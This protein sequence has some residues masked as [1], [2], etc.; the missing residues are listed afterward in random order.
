MLSPSSSP[1]P[2]RGFGSDN[3]SG[4]HPAILA[5]I[6]A[7]NEGHAP[8]YQTDPHSAAA[9]A[10]FAR[11]LGPVTVRYVFNGTGANV[12]ALQAITPAYGAVLCADTA[13]IHVD[14]C[15]APERFIGCKLLA[16]RGIHGKLT[17]ELLAPYLIRGGDQHFAAP[18]AVSIAQ[19]TELGT[20]Y[21]PAELQ[22]L[23]EFAHAKG[24]RV[25]LDGARLVNAAAAL[26]VPL[27]A[28]TTDVG[29]DV[30][31]FGGTKNGLLGGEAVIFFDPALARDFNYIRKQGMQLP[32]KTRF[33]AAQFEA[34]LGGDL[35]RTNAIHANAMA[36]RLAD[37]VADVPSVKL[38]APVETNALFAE[39]PKAWVK[40]LREQAFF[41]VW[42]ERRTAVRW[43]TTFDTTPEDVDAFLA[44]IHR[45]AK[46]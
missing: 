6:V 40:P 14:E 4:V 26:D 36:R 15:G 16:V 10:I 32:S 34:L 44:E 18:R 35:W 5:A 43:M 20:V 39:I 22:N 45:L 11:H 19:P 46:G 29:I 3:H 28:L 7:A 41:Y 30:L 38:L 33:V 37:G 24:L 9:D 2:R 31:S 17:P 12:L 21:T 42:D 13:H 8:A 1:R 23:C 25:H 27:R